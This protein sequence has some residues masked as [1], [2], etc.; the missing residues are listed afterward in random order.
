MVEEGDLPPDLG[1][2]PSGRLDFG[3]QVSPREE[4]ARLL[5]EANDK[6]SAHRVFAA[7]T[8][9]NQRCARQ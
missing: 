5:A 2:Q 9:G 8:I 3:E 6:G 4:P 1:P 7:Q